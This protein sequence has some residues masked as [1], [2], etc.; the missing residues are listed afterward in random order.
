MSEHSKWIEIQLTPHLS[1]R[2]FRCKCRTKACQ[3]T[4]IGEVFKIAYEN[5]RIKAGVNFRIN[6]GFRCESHNKK[7]GGA[8]KSKHKLGNAVDIAYTQKI[9]E[10]FTS[11]EF[12]ELGKASGF[13]YAYYDEIKN[14]FHFDTRES[15]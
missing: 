6:S 3:V 12:V 4:K 8:E 15:E 9:K 7:I 2:E 11:Q 14:F 5:F 1:N 13:L 10:K